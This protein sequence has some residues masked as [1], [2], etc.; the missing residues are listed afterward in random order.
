[1]V[2]VKYEMWHKKKVKYTYTNQ[3][4]YNIHTIYILLTIQIF[5]LVRS[6]KNYFCSGLQVQTE[7]VVTEG[8]SETGQ[9]LLSTSQENIGPGLGKG[10][11]RVG[12]NM[13]IVVIG[14]GTRISIEKA[15]EWMAVTIDD[16]M[17]INTLNMLLQFIYIFLYIQTTHLKILKKY[18]KRRLNFKLKTNCQSCL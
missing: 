5:F 13:S 2:N 16:N 14:Q 8:K 15:R 17:I 6:L 7:E 18:T 11:V 9:I 3:Y 4:T 1:M 12:A 10:W